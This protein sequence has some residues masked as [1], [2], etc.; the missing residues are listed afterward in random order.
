[1]EPQHKIHRRDYTVEQCM[2]YIWIQSTVKYSGFQENY[3]MNVFFIFVYKLKSQTLTLFVKYKCVKLHVTR[4]N[5]FH[6]IEPCEFRHKD[7]IAINEN[8]YLAHTKT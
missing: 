6:C 4:A 7:I 1:M 5:H 2:M 8:M 3:Q